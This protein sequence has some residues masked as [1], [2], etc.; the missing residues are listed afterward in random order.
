MAGQRLTDKSSLTT[1]P[2]SDD[3]LMIVDKSDTTGGSLGTSKKIDNKF[4]IQ[5][6]KTAVSAAEFQAM[7]ATGGGGT[8]KTLISAPG[9]GYFINVLSAYIVVDY[10]SGTQVAKTTLYL[11][12]ITNTSVYFWSSVKSFMS[13]ETSDNVYSASAQEGRTINGGASA[14]ENKGFY[15]WAGANYVSAFDANIYVTYQ[16]VTL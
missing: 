15:V 13:Q 14:I 7:D 6:D 2:T 5:T 12:Y 16:I 10:T 4:I 11:G 1:N 9:A 8:F 3:L